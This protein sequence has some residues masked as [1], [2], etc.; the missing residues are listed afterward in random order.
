MSSGMPPVQQLRTQFPE[1]LSELFSPG[2]LQGAQISTKRPRR[3]GSG[4]P[5][6][7]QPLHAP[8]LHFL[9]QTF[10]AVSISA[11]PKLL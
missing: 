3:A 7:V 9:P 5:K 6:C 11:A 10:L 2:S 4:E 1:F 8:H